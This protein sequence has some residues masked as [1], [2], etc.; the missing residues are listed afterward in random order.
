MLSF[1]YTK[2]MKNQILVTKSKSK[3]PCTKEQPNETINVCPPL[4]QL[5]TKQDWF[6]FQFAFSIC[7]LVVSILGGCFYFY[8]LGKKED[9]SD[10][11]LANYNVY[12]L[13]SSR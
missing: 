9:F 1:V 13:Y 10:K 2:F 11:L 4:S 6:K 5:S 3:T 12:R 8:Q 7:I